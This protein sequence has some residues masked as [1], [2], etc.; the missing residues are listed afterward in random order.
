MSGQHSNYLGNHSGR[1]Y[2]HRTKAFSGCTALTDVS[3]PKSLQ[4]IGVDAFEKCPVKSILIS[5]DLTSGQYAL[6]ATHSKQL[7]LPMA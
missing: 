6:T 2:K 7:H 1:C 3:L 4:E 5:G